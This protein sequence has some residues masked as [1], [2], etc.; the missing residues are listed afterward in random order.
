[1]GK[2]VA[3]RITFKVLPVIRDFKDY[4]LKFLMADKIF[5]QC[6]GRLIN[7]CAA[8]C[9]LKISYRMMIR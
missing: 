5:S 9:T 3:A 6:G 8:V 1:M 4:D 7:R 2:Q